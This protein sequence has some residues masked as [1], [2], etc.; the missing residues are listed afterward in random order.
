MHRT[1]GW[2]AD[3]FRGIPVDTAF[4]PN[5]VDL[6]DAPPA[7]LVFCANHRMGRSWRLDISLLVA[8]VRGRGNR[9]QDGSVDDVAHQRRHNGHRAAST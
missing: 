3:W 8:G 4:D 2:F 7:K 5:G 9:P 1:L 6:P